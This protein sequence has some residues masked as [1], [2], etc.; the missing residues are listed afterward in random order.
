MEDESQA[1]EITDKPKKRPSIGTK[2]ELNK[3]KRLA[4]HETGPDC[5]C[6]RFECFIK[7]S[8]E[9]RSH[10]I[11]HFNSLDTKDEQDALLCT[12]IH[13]NPV[14]RRRSRKAKGE[15]ETHDYAYEY[16]VNVIREET[17][18]RVKVCHKAFTALFGI[19]RKRVEIAR[20]K[21]TKTGLSIYEIKKLFKIL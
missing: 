1:P 11:A 15:G 13:C 4:E 7:L 3:K 14:H 10:I 21:V 17:L 16:F 18:T 2:R 20:S 8:F 12:L 5:H 9:E 19:S 6:K